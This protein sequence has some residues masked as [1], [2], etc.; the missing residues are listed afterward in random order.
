[1]RRKLLLL[2]GSTVFGLLMLELL[3]H[4]VMPPV[5]PGMAT[6]DT[7]NAALYSW[8]LPPNSWMSEADPDTGRVSY[9]RTNARGWKDREHTLAKPETT[10]RIVV[11]G[12]S[13]TYGV[14]P[15]DQQYTTRVEAMLRER[16][17]PQCE[18]ISIGVSGW[19]TDQALEALVSEGLRYQPDLVIY[20]FCSNDLLEN[21]YPEPGMP[22]PTPF[23]RVKH[24]RYERLPDGGLQKVALAVK[25]RK[26]S[27]GQRI[28]RAL[29]SSALVCLVD[30]AVR[31]RKGRP[32]RGALDG[33]IDLQ[34][35]TLDPESPY[36]PY[37]TGEEPSETK[38]AWDLLDALVRRMDQESRSHGA[39]F[40]VFSESGD[41][42][43]RSWFLEQGLIQS[44]PGGDRVVARGTTHPLD[45]QRPLKNLER[46][47]EAA[48]IPMIRPTRSYT[49]YHNDSHTNAEGNE[50]MAA[51]IVDYLTRHTRLAG[52]A[53]RRVGASVWQTSPTSGL[54]R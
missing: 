4:W 49:R 19:G 33:A 44:D 35:N 1:M 39:E 8:A 46:I 6:A 13:Y 12:D 30:R 52:M 37:A 38:R 7:P 54:V 42:G 22:P 26:L 16:G 23:H 9:F 10:F 41:E 28:H 34:A 47:C 5:L 11:L 50:R 18:V 51:D 36:F 17:W 45:L 25:P 20:Q 48:M 24:F 21:L 40:L 15:M 3:L 14:V 31:V 29:R 53:E 43:R 32:R 2:S 27:F